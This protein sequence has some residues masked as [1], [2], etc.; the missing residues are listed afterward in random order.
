MAA[1]T[2]PIVAKQ[3]TRSFVGIHV[4]NLAAVSKALRQCPL[5]MQ[6]ELKLAMKSVAGIAARRAQSFAPRASGKLADSIKPRATL[7]GAVV[8]SR[9]AY[10]P[11]IE[12][13]RKAVY[14]TYVRKLTQQHYLIPAIRASRAEMVAMMGPV[15]KH[16]LDKAMRDQ[17]LRNAA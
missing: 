15:V 17:G 7:R 2:G 10:A 4:E 9:L 12:F 1:R 5:E 13:G 11:V 3:D 8:G 16:A 14:P 6:R